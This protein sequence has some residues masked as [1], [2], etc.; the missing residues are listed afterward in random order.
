MYLWFVLQCAVITR[1]VERSLWPFLFLFSLLILHSFSLSSFNWEGKVSPLHTFSRI[2]LRKMRIAWV[3]E[4][5]FNNW[6]GILYYVCKQLPCLFSF[7]SVLF[8]LHL[9]HKC[10]PSRDHHTTSELGRRTRMTFVH[11]VN[12]VHQN[13]WW[14]ERGRR[15]EGERERKHV[16][17]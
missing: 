2:N 3:S 15:R 12:T 9:F 4:R 16:H 10:L 1:P 13:Q 8:F 11:N 17:C 7:F 14:R 5:H 6:P